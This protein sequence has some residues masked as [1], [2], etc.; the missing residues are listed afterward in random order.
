M[1]ATVDER[2]ASIPLTMLTKG[3]FEFYAFAQLL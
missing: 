2:F 1:S 3:Q